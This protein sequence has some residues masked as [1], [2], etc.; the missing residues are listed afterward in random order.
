VATGDLLDITSAEYLID[1]GDA[2]GQGTLRLFVRGRR[3]LSRVIVLGSERQLKLLFVH[4]HAQ[5]SRVMRC[6][7]A[8]FRVSDHVAGRPLACSRLSA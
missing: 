4:G 2:F 8:F 1:S 3:G 7:T 6:V 5:L